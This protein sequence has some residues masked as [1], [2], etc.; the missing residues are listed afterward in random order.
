MVTIRIAREI[1]KRLVVDLIT[2]GYSPTKVI[3]FGSVAKTNTHRYS[4]MDIAICDE[5]FTGCWP[6]DIE[7]V[8]KILRGYPR[9]EL[10]TFH[11]SETFQDNPF[12]TEIEKDGIVI[13]CTTHLATA[14]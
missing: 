9:V 2:I 8:V 4:D 12:I 7:S 11:S 14:I 6:I 1:I 13:G 10:H 5:G 3:L